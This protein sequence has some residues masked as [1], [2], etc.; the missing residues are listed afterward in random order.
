MK[1]LFVEDEPVLL[2]E[3]LSYFSSDGNICEQANDYGQAVEKINTYAYDGIVLD[4]TLP[5]G[6]GID[7]IP[8]IRT[9][10]M[11]TGILILSA[12]NSLA[13]KVN[14]LNLGADDYLTKPF[15]LEELSARVNA[16]YRRKALQGEENI[17]F[18]GF[19]IDTA[20]KCLM[21]GTEE[22][23]LTKKEYQLLIYFVVNKNRVVSKSAIA[24]HIWGDSFD[25]ADNF[26]VIY[27]HMMNLRKKLIKTNGTDYIKTVRGLGYKFVS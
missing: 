8:Q 14:G 2:D 6:N 10:Q 13:D 26:D 24:E 18:D 22:I 27:V 12:K 20:G 3:M 11:G 1:L 19:T 7:L 15:Y 23:K 17:L 5:D 21:Y 16:L 9:C 4:I 25:E